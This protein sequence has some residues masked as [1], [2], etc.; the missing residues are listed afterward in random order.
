MVMEIVECEHRICAL[1]P[2]AIQWSPPLVSESEISATRTQ[3]GAVGA[4]GLVGLRGGV[5]RWL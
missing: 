1:S 3:E 2:C 4:V 5:L